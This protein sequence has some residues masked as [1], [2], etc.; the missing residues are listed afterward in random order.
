MG[1]HFEH[2]D[3]CS[4]RR[5]WWDVRDHSC[6]TS[7]PELPSRGADG[8]VVEAAEGYADLHN[9]L[10]AHLAFGE[11]VVWGKLWG[12]PATALSPIPASLAGPHQRIEGFSTS[13]G[14]LGVFGSHDE[15]GHPSYTGWPTPHL[16]T[17]QQTY[18]DWLFRAYQGGLRLV[19]APAVNN[20]DM[21]GRGENPI[22]F[23]NGLMGLVGAR[24]TPAPHRTSNDME[25]LEFQV[26]AAHAFERWVAKHQGGWLAVAETPEEAAELI[27]AG[28][29]ALVLGSEV[30]HLFNC[31]LGRRCSKE[32]VDRNLDRMDALG[33]AILFPQHHKVT[34]FGDSA[35]FQPLGTGP[36]TEC[37]EM[38]MDCAAVGLTDLGRHLV[39]GMM[40]RGMLVDLGHAGSK[41][42]DDTMTLLEAEN[43]PTQMTHASAHPLEPNGSAEYTLTWE[44]IRRIDALDGMVSIHGASGEYAG[45]D[46]NGTGI[47]LG[48]TEGGAAFVQS[49]LYT[50]EAM[51][52]GRVGPSGQIA[53]APDWNGFADW[54]SG[55]FAAAGCGAR[56]LANGTPLPIAPRLEYPLPLPASLLRATVGGAETLPRMAW[57]ERVFD[58][59]EVGLAHAGL[60]PDL[61]EDMRLHGL[62]EADL[63]PFYRSARG[64]IEMWRRAREAN[65]AGD[66]GWLRWIPQSPTDLIEFE[67]LATERLVTHAPGGVVCRRRSTGEVGSLVEGRCRVPGGTDVVP[68]VLSSVE[69]RNANSGMCLEPKSGSRRAGSGLA[70]STCNDSTRQQWQLQ[71]EDSSTE[72]FRLWSSDSDRCLGETDSS[73]RPRIELQVCSDSKRQRFSLERIGNTFR[74]RGVVS[75]RC[76]QTGRRSLEAGA[77]VVLAPCPP[78]G[79]ADFHWEIDGL[80]DVVDYEL[81]FSTRSLADVVA[82]RAEPDD[83]FPH[84]V[85]GTEGELCRSSSSRTLGVVRNDGCDAAGAA[86]E[87]FERLLSA[88]PVH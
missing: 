40:A 15:Q 75:Q 11:T 72:I 31:D 16:K 43:Y 55:R 21:F 64:F 57:Q 38:T 27:E 44:Q 48:C 62:S 4:G 70:Q 10:F 76:L 17:H 53:L 60:Q 56:T 79:R 24:A 23:L 52:G 22:G 3:G 73:D 35:N 9:H 63:D 30:D 18:V 34:Q 77:P 46:N 59:N 47:P 20:Q 61:L 58:F 1:A 26:R 68:L 49:Y 50:R 6:G 7:L 32:M 54:P 86:A 88:T 12:P 39:R 65:V 28:K 87:G 67:D 14:L 80:R 41:P 78:P 51:G 33:L 81:L 2:P 5:G 42:F 13:R 66:R 25:A 85:A 71:R 45:V 69:I 82:W 19:V 29:L 8:G 84:A 83:D 36:V 37:P 74:L